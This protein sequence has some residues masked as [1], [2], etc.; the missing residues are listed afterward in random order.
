MLNLLGLNQ[1]PHEVGEIA[2]QG[3]KLKLDFVVS[4]SDACHQVLA[5]LYSSIA[6]STISVM[7][8]PSAFANAIK[9][10]LVSGAPHS[11]ARR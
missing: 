4:E 2:G 11:R 10:A 1:G 5:A 6:A 8:R 3:V 9:P 7:V